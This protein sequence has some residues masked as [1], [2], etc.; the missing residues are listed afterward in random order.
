MTRATIGRHD[1]CDCYSSRS[2]ERPSADSGVCTQVGPRRRP[3]GAMA[4]VKEGGEVLGACI[5]RLSVS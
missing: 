5:S 4:E 2:R 1:E 3:S